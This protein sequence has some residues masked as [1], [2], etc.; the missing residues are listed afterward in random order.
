[1]TRIALWTKHRKIAR[2]IA[3]DFTL[4]GHDKQDVLQEAEIGLW[5]ATG[6][7]DPERSPFTA[8]ARMAV[9]AH[10]TDCLRV[11]TRLRSRMLSEAVRKITLP[12][13]VIVDATDT[14]TDTRSEPCRKSE[15]LEMLRLIACAKMAPFERQVLLHVLQGGTYEEIQA[16]TFRSYRGVENAFQRAKRKVMA[17]S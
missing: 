1:M 12:S 17:C 3:A 9:K 6:R 16:E 4:P 5:V 13:G 7:W 11:A 8:Y 2:D 15:G 10:L 14:I